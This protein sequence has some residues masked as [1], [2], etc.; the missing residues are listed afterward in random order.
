M[1]YG[2]RGVLSA[3]LAVG[4]ILGTAGCS[5]GT[6]GSVEAFCNEVRKNSAALNRPAVGVGVDNQTILETHVEAVQSVDKKTPKAIKPQVDYISDKAK[7]F[8]DVWKEGGFK[9]NAMPE[10]DEGLVSRYHDFDAYVSDKCS[11][12]L[13]Q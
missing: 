13:T 5:G 10:F 8:L 11:V 6:S 9:S 4:A 12:K 7:N 2:M 1:R 3:A